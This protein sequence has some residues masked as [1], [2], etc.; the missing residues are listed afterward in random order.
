MEVLARSLTLDKRNTNR[1]G[2]GPKREIKDAV[3]SLIHCYSSNFAEKFLEIKLL[4]YSF[5]PGF[6]A[7]LNLIKKHISPAI[8][9]I[10]LPHLLRIPTVEIYEKNFYIR[11]VLIYV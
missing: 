8:Q 4:E 1:A 9:N 2:D 3:S 7:V 6:N 11:Y 10:P 5:Y